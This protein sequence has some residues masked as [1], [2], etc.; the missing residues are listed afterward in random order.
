[1]APEKPQD[2][3]TMAPNDQDAEE[4]GNAAAREAQEDLDEAGV[5]NDNAE[6]DAPA[7]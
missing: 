3:G 2:E 1:M 4:A 7:S 5:D 6:A